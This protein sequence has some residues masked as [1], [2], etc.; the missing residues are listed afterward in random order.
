MEPFHHST[1]EAAFGDG[2]QVLAHGAHVHA[3]DELLFEVKPSDPATFALVAAMLG[4][5]VLGACLIPARR[6]TR[7]DPM[8]ALRYE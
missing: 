7:V 1:A 3:L 8:V 2:L 5:V 6:A 4:V